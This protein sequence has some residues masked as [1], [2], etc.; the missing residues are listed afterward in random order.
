M[1]RQELVVLL[2]PNKNVAR[3]WNVKIQADGPYTI[4][5]AT[6][7]LARPG[8][9]PKYIFA[10]AEN[11]SS[12]V[13]YLVAF[14][15]DGELM[16]EDLDLEGALFNTTQLHGKR[17]AWVSAA[18]VMA[19]HASDLE[20]FV[21]YAR[22]VHA[23]ESGP[24]RYAWNNKTW[25][26][27]VFH[28][29]EAPR[30]SVKEVAQQ[31]KLVLTA[32]VTP[33]V[34]PPR[35]TEV[36]PYYHAFGLDRNTGPHSRG[37]GGTKWPN[38]PPWHD[39]E[40][41]HESPTLRVF[42]AYG[43]DGVRERDYVAQ[44]SY[45][46]KRFAFRRFDLGV[47][48]KVINV[49]SFASKDEMVVEL[50][51]ALVNKR[52][53]IMISKDDAAR[54]P[55]RFN[56]DYEEF[57]RSASITVD[58]ENVDAYYTLTWQEL[59]KHFSSTRDTVL[60]FHL[61]MHDPE[62]HLHME[63]EEAMRRAIRLFLTTPIPMPMRVQVSAM[64]FITPVAEVCT[65]HSTIDRAGNVTTYTTVA[66]QKTAITTDQAVNELFA[67]AKND[68]PIHIAKEV[69]VP[70]AIRNL[71]IYGENIVALSYNIWMTRYR[72]GMLSGIV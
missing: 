27:S 50:L 37:T 24:D 52:L 66:G 18:D 38:S 53:P 61:P 1:L 56:S 69:V 13:H 41:T 17:H 70:A 8:K 28:H 45:P 7:H 4:E 22:Q 25:E 64:I 46:A 57:F 39:A 14:L 49:H 33:T 16:M 42:A 5:S 55:T 15:V 2:S 3:K 36:L 32:L 68:V 21:E 10:V 51:D 58:R 60:A 65:Y 12:E 47:Q 30:R 54:V 59:Y 71:F 40:V 34:I 29:P 72:I 43:P 6:I 62:L 23:D 19:Y 63:A 11:L 31:I 9:S 67:A 20:V 35:E 44:F 26:R 48:R